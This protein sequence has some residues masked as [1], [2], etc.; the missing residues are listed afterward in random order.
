M[1][2]EDIPRTRRRIA[3]GGPVAGHISLSFPPGLKVV[4]AGE[5]SRYPE[6]IDVLV[7]AGCRLAFTC[8]DYKTGQALA[9]KSGARHLPVEHTDS[10]TFRKLLPGLTRAWLGAPEII[11]KVGEETLP[12][13]PGYLYI[14][15]PEGFDS[16]YCH[17]GIP[18]PDIPAVLYSLLP[19]SRKI[20]P[21]GYFKL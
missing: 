17:I 11:I 8:G 13:M 1:R 10:E 6:L 4:L 3:P 5:C 12:G 9:Q 15:I 14:G 7:A 20:L 21:S 19:F 16:S 2:G 18:R